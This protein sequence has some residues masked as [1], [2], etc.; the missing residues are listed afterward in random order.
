MSRSPASPSPEV[1]V[2]HGN[3]RDLTPL[4]E[5]IELKCEPCGRSAWYDVGAVIISPRFGADK[6]ASVEEYASFTRYFHCRYC[7]AGG[8]WRVAPQAQVGLTLK[9]MVWLK[10]RQPTGVYFGE[11]RTFD[12]KW[13]RYPTQTAAYV[14]SLLKRAP[15]SAELWLR[16]GNVYANGGRPDLALAPFR[17]GIELEPASAELHSQLAQCFEAMNRPGDAVAEWL[18]LL[19]RA[20][21]DRT[22]EPGI[23]EK[24]VS[25]ALDRV[26]SAD[27]FTE[28][29]AI[30]NRRGDAGVDPSR[31]K[32]E[33]PVTLYLTSL[34]FSKQKHWDRVC[35]MFI[36]GPLAF[37]G[38]HR[39]PG[40]AGRPTA[41]QS[42]PEGRNARCSCGS[43]R[44]YKK[45]CGAPSKTPAAG[46]RGTAG[47]G[48]H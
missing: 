7:D 8:P 26:L 47:V 21:D 17:R 19:E 13:F 12:G 3:P 33:E 41:P 37:A 34:D 5:R 39:T 28:A 46:Q 36:E 15:D 32:V 44:K 1:R 42:R 20:A 9:G 27:R 11:T 40:P 48:S 25:M 30:L 6:E 31:T 10:T 23:L 14:R 45:C 22:T 2:I 16:L 18:T 4:G 38:A 29:I 35:R 24:L 43:G